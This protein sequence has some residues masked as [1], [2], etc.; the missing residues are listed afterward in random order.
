MK[1]K[2]T[3]TQVQKNKIMANKLQYFT[4]L[5]YKEDEI[6]HSQHTITLITKEYTP[7]DVDDVG[8]EWEAAI[9]VYRREG[10]P[11]CLALDEDLDCTLENHGDKKTCGIKRTLT[12]TGVK[13][14]ILFKKRLAEQQKTVKIRL[15]WLRED[16][17]QTLV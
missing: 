6:R 12:V 16:K 15:I 10:S 1:K 17:Q 2:K 14:K 5:H 3:V 4:L 7:P 11:I 8:T 9:P 13:L